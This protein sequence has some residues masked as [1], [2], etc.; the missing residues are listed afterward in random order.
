MKLTSTIDH[1][2]TIEEHLLYLASPESHTKLRNANLPR[3]VRINTIRE[4]LTRGLL[5]LKMIPTD[6]NGSIVEYA[7]SPRGQV[8]LTDLRKGKQK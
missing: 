4:L 8:R 7:L 5:Q 3:G 1:G 2:I 6:S